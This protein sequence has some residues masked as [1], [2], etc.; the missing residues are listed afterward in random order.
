[1]RWEREGEDTCHADNPK[2]GSS[3][4]CS[5]PN[6]TNPFKRLVMDDR[7]DDARLGSVYD[8]DDALRL[9]KFKRSVKDMKR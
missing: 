9:R 6:G 2:K 5:S 8:W 1:M 4:G 7:K 3:C